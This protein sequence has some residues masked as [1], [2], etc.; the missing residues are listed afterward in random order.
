MRNSKAVKTFANNL[1]VDERRFL[2]EVT[3]IAQQGDNN[4]DYPIRQ[5]GNTFIAVP[6]SRMNYEMNRINRLGGNIINISPIGVVTPLV[7]A[8]QTQG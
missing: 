5:S 1:S 8:A 6:Y 2:F 7:A 3:G 4:L